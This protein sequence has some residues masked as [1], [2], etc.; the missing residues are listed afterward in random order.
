MASPGSARRPAGRQGTEASGLAPRW[1]S[2]RTRQPWCSAKPPLA[3]LPSASHANSALYNVEE[4]VADPSHQHTLSK[5]CDFLRILSVLI[6]P[7]NIPGYGI[8]RHVRCTIYHPGP[9]RSRGHGRFGALP[10]QDLAG[11]EGIFLHVVP[12]MRH[13][14]MT[15][16]GSS[17]RPPVSSPEAAGPIRGRQADRALRRLRAAGYESASQRRRLGAGGGRHFSSR[18][19]RSRNALVSWRAQR[20]PPE[21]RPRF[22]SAGC[23]E[24]PLGARPRGGA[25]PRW[26]SKR[27]A[28]SDGIPRNADC[29]SSISPRKANAAARMESL[30]DRRTTPP[31]KSFS[32][33]RGARSHT[34]PWSHGI[35]GSLPQETEA[36][37]EA[38]RAPRH[39]WRF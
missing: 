3:I 36:P 13:I 37:R 25:F 24:E 38:S 6:Y 35:H 28:A 31:S 5:G 20:R 16:A 8:N 12:W 1:A 23:V 29:G 7:N 34:R 4:G 14:E 30:K 27:S 22:S 19:I 10:S 32:P 18:P 33:N 2:C 11:S 15:T 17:R 21:T 26:L 39:E 9:S